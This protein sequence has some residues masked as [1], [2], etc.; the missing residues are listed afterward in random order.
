LLHE[1]DASAWRLIGTLFFGTIS[2]IHALSRDMA[3][4]DVIMNNPGYSGHTKLIKQFFLAVNV[5]GANCAFNSSED[6]MTP[7]KRHSF[8]KI[9][10]EF[11]G[12]GSRL[13]APGNA[14][15]ASLR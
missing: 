10:S 9:R 3:D 7:G 14:R 4:S 2:S 5:C 1:A 13:S 12:L 8:G 11:D 6:Q 15:P